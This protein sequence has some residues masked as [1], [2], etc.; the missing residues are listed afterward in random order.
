MLELTLRE[1]MELGHDYIG[2]EH[3]LLGMLAEGEGVGVKV[4]SGLGMDPAALRTTVL[5]RVRATAS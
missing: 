1:S 3:L 5:N 2:T 4:L